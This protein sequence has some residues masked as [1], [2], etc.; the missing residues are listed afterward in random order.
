[1][2]TTIRREPAVRV[3][4]A[5]GRVHDRSS[6]LVMGICCRSAGALSVLGCVR[7]DLKTLR[8]VAVATRATRA[9]TQPRTAHAEERFDA[10][11]ALAWIS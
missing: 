7:C 11:L 2:A 5:R 9:A 4:R 8:D 3:Y 6:K 10:R 1:M